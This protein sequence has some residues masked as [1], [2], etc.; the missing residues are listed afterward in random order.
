MKTL[1][2][3]TN[4]PDSLPEGKA[5]FLLAA[6][7]TRTCEIEGITQAGIPGKIPLTPTLDAE[8]I[9]NEKV[10]SMPELAE[11]PKGVPTPAL[12]TRAVHKLTPYS[13]IEVLNLGL[14]AVPQK[15]PIQSFDI[16]PSGSVASGANIDARTVFEKGMIAGKNYELKGNYLILAES[17]PGGTTTATTTALALGYDCRNDFSSSF[18]NSPDS[19]KEKTINEALSLLDEDMTNFEKLSLVSDNMLIFYAGFLLEASR[20]FH[21]VLAGGTQMAACLLVADKLKEDVLMRIK[22]DNI[23]LATTSWVANDENSDIKHILSLLSYT[24]HAV[25]TS[26]SFADTEIPV[27]KLYDEGEAKEGVGAGA[28]LAYANTNGTTNKELLDAIELLIYSM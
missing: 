20:R 5:D 13:N 18:L 22:S 6:S 16:Y 11:T 4:Q 10:F 23:T 3:F 26:F 14:D 19:I 28:A 27:L 1:N 9:T 21:V 7:V 25:H 12:I 8:F 17:T 24:P 2:I 15:T